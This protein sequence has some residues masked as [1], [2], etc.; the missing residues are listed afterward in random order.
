MDE[1]FKAKQLASLD[2]VPGMRELSFDEL[3]SVGGAARRTTA[4]SGEGITRGEIV[5]LALGG[6]IG[7]H[8]YRRFR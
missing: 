2:D 7:Y 4:D 3:D 1:R 6:L 8:L 5:A